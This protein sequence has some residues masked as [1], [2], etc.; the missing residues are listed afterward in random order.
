MEKIDGEYAALIN[1]LGRTPAICKYQ[2]NWKFDVLYE[3]LEHDFGRE[4][5]VRRLL[6]SIQDDIRC[7][8]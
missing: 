2:I 3:L 6:Q 5:V 8:D 1:E 7:I 4:D